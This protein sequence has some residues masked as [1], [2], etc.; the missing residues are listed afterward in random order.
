MAV[1]VERASLSFSGRE[2]SLLPHSQ[3]VTRLERKVGRDEI[4]D[5][6]VAGEYH[7]IFSNYL[8]LFCLDLLPD[9]RCNV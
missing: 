5:C 1:W 9:D 4:M 3:F 8:L 7:F 2:C 6:C